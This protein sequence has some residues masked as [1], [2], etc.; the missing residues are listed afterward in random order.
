MS[1]SIKVMAEVMEK[2]GWIPEVDPTV[3]FAAEAKRTGLAAFLSPILPDPHSLALWQG[4]EIQSLEGHHPNHCL[5]QV[6]KFHWGKSC[7]QG[8]SAHQRQSLDQNP[9][10]CSELQ[11]SVD[12]GSRMA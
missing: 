8:N 5:V 2:R 4:P 7:A 12:T 10:V 3:L 11:C 1:L 6:P 9:D